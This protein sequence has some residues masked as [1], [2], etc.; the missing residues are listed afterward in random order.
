MAGGSLELLD[1]RVLMAE[2][3]GPELAIAGHAV[4]LS[5]WHAVWIQVS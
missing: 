4:A 3:S 5:Q 2:L 1:L